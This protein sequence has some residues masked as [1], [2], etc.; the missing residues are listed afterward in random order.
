MAGEWT[1]VKP[2]RNVGVRLLLRVAN[3]KLLS[4]T[5]SSGFYAC[6]FSD[7]PFISSPTDNHSYIHESRLSDGS[8]GLL[9]SE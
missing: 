3:P 6:A 5:V 7:R 1:Q 9:P 2:L 8:F 4:R